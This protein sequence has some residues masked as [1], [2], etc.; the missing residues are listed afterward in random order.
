MAVQI[1]G[2][3]RAYAHIQERLRVGIA[4][5][6]AERFRREVATLLQQVEA[7]CQ[8]HRLTP[9][10]LPAPS[11]RAYR[12]L[13]TL[14]L[15]ALPLREADVPAPPA[16]TI[17]LTN[18]VAVG[19]HLADR[20]W[21]EREALE[22]A[23]ARR[24]LH[25]TLERHTLDVE[26]ICARQKLT[27]AALA[28]PSRAVY[29]WLKFL[30]GADNLALHLQALRRARRAVAASA[31]QLKLPTAVHL[32]HIS[33]LWRTR[34]FRTETILTVSEGF[35]AADDDVWLALLQQALLRRD[36][37]S[38]QLVDAFAG[39]EA[40]SAVLYELA[41][42]A[43]SPTAARGHI[44]DL[45]ASFNRVNAAYFAGQLA[46]PVLCWSKAPT[47]RTFGHYQS[48]RDTVMVSASLDV[49][50]VPEFVI[51]HVMHHEL[52]HKQLG[53]TMANGRTSVHGPA[54]RAAERR[55][56]RYAEAAAFLETLARSL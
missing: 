54:F 18:L 9:D 38:R 24:E 4:P 21:Q 10:Q 34:S 32:T 23:A 2:L 50:T 47:A 14:D 30:A 41:S 28:A 20:L 13:K 35:A 8:Q 26:R 43:S 29:C 37:S 36:A 7:I 22:S 39:T 49:G 33:P 27:P 46:R 44:H 48:T 40:F 42:F 12:F 3:L 15:S 11:R 25:T 6:D 17:R 1:R 19:A 16:G 31:E 5:V 45:D 53:V 52:L 56:P 55:Y 51:D